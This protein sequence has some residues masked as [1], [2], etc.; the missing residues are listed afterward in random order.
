MITNQ[1]RR[2]ERLE[3][4][5]RKAAAAKQSQ[6]AEHSRVQEAVRDTF[7][8]ATRY[9]RTYNEHWMDD[10]RPEPEEPFPPYPYFKD[11]SI[12]STWSV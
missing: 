7:V 8:W 6:L 4:V 12:F 2:I 10:G 3:E 5:E 11:L 1:E 9:T